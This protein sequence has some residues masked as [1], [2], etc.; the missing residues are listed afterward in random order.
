M[1]HTLFI[2]VRFASPRR[3]QQLHKTYDF[4]ENSMEISMTKTRSADF[5]ADRIDVITNFAVITKPL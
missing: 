1:N 4:L 5:C 2:F 3:F